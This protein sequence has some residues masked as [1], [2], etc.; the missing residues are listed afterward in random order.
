VG[1][2]N[3]DDPLLL[4][5]PVRCFERPEE[6]QL[7]SYVANSPTRWLDKDGSLI[8][9]PIFD[10]ALSTDIAVL[11]EQIQERIKYL[12]MDARG[13]ELFYHWLYGD[14]RPFEANNG[15]WGVYLNNNKILSEQIDWK[16]K[17]DA[18]V[19][20]ES[21]VFFKRFHVDMQSGFFTGY[22]ML[23]GTHSEVG[24]FELIGNANV[25][26]HPVN[27]LVNYELKGTWNDIMDPN[28][29]HIGDR[30]FDTLFTSILKPKNY[31]VRFSWNLVRN[32]TVNKCT[33]EIAIMS[34]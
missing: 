6:C 11:K 7:Y 13:N 19:R 22:Q 10:L 27:K 34:S 31:R 17:V 12:G 28:Y 1:R 30:L 5:N 33:K 24:D 20:K 4:E 9:T 29:N 8:Y 14:G 25:R 2:F 21:G 16:V 32:V 3:A 15:E 18:V 26:E 23:G